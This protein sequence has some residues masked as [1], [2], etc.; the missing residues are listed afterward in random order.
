MAKFNILELWKRNFD[1]KTS[2]LHS[3]KHPI[4]LRE[5][6][7]FIFKIFNDFFGEEYFQI[8]KIKYSKEQKLVLDRNSIY[9][10]LISESDNSFYTLL[11][12]AALISFSKRLN[13]D[14]Y[15]KLVSVKNDYFGLREY[16]FEVFVYRLLINGNIPFKIKP[17]INGKEFEALFSFNEKPGIIECKKIYSIERNR[18]SYLQ[19]NFN[20]FFKKWMDYQIDVFAFFFAP[21]KDLNVLSEESELVKKHISEYFELVRKEKN[22][23]FLFERF[24]S[25]GEKILH[26]ERNKPGLLDN[27]RMVFK[28]PYVFFSA[29]L[30]PLHGNIESSFINFY[31]GYYFSFTE[32]EIE[33]KIIK[34]LKKKRNQHKETKDIY[35]VFF[36]EN[37]GT[38]FGEIPLITN[39]ILKSDYILNYLKQKNSNDIVCIVDKNFLPNQKPT[40][41]LYIYNKPELDELGNELSKLKIKLFNA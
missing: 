31:S 6:V 36:F 40:V 38:S 8:D 16:L 10:L 20:L 37:E 32:Q 39:K 41:N 33:N 5:S 28:T 18:Y 1:Y 34:E 17:E 30:T 22:I 24:N 2:N 13:V 3:K 15:N 26:I 25:K 23:N 7:T 21:S 14:L 29:H 19:N 35:R 11:D 27:L 4:I 12:M 9:Q